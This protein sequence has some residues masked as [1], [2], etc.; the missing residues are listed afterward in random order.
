MNLTITYEDARGNVYDHAE[1]PR[2]PR[3]ARAMARETLRR[4]PEYVKAAISQTKRLVRL[5]RR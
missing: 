4:N 5:R 2:T 3:E 1:R